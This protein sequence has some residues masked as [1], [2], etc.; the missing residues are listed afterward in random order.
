MSHQGNKSVCQERFTVWIFFQ[1]AIVPLIQKRH[2]LSFALC[3]YILK[4]TVIFVCILIWYIMLNRN[5]ITYLGYHITVIHDLCN[6]TYYTFGFFFFTCFVI[7]F[8]WFVCKRKM[9]S[10]WDGRRERGRNGARARRREGPIWVLR[11]WRSKPLCNVSALHLM[12]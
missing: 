8:S 1:L 11:K 6:V 2:L 7:D 3:L 9:T 4:Y 10:S 5:I 12:K